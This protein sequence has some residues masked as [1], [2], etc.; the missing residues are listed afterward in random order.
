MKL[1]KERWLTLSYLRFNY[2]VGRSAAVITVVNATA[3]LG[4]IF[5][6][7]F[8]CARNSSRL[9]LLV[10]GLLINLDVMSRWFSA[11][12][13]SQLSSIG[14]PLWGNLTWL[15]FCPDFIFSFLSESRAEPTIKVIYGT[16]QWRKISIPSIK[17]IIKCVKCHSGK[18]SRGE[19]VEFKVS[20]ERKANINKWILFGK[21]LTDARTFPTLSTS[22]SSL[23]F[24]FSSLS[25]NLGRW[26]IG[27]S[28]PAQNIWILLFSS[29][30]AAQHQ[31]QKQRCA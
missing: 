7:K 25:H 17:Y 27:H 10:I 11:G 6:S 3:A 22:S 26:T 21:L 14:H 19:Q 16:Q 31:G 29:Y 20:D 8:L 2:H 23:S 12:E 28:S 13:E 18:S 1:R 15:E 30:F 5:P 24:S 4:G 9:S